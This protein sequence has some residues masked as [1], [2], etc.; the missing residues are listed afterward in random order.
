MK[1]ARAVAL[2]P[3]R[4]YGA[5]GIEELKVGKVVVVCYVV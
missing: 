5:V 4:Y 1:S 3:S 2:D